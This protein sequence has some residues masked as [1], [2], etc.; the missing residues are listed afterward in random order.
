MVTVK[1]VVQKRAIQ[2]GYLEESALEVLFADGTSVCCTTICFED[3][4][5]ELDDLQ[6][7]LDPA[8]AAKIT[9]GDFVGSYNSFLLH[10]LKSKGK[11]T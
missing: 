10:L 6:K 3:H 11:L 1:K 4:G 5:C 8:E 7:K 9:T 2:N